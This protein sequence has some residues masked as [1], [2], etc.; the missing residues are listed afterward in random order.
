[1]RPLMA[2]FRCCYGVVW[3]LLRGQNGAV[4]M[5]RNFCLFRRF[6]GFLTV[7]KTLIVGALSYRL[8]PIRERI[9]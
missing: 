1:M 6:Q 3:G 4:L 7:E 8:R 9:V 5:C 2:L